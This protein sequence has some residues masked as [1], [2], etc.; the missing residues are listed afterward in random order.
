MSELSIIKIII[1]GLQYLNPYYV[2]DVF[3]IISIALFSI[4]IYKRT[5]II[6]TLLASL[7]IFSTILLISISIS[8]FDSN[9]IESSIPNLL[10]G[11]ITALIFGFINLLLVLI[12][13]FIKNRKIPEKSEITPTA[14]YLTLR[15]I[16]TYNNITQ[17]PLLNNIFEQLRLSQENTQRIL[18]LHGVGVSQELDLL[19]SIKNA[20]I[21]EDSLIKQIKIEIINGFNKLFIELGDQTETSNIAKIHT[22]LQNITSQINSI[23]ATKLATSLQAIQP[24]LESLQQLRIQTNDTFPKIEQNLTELIKGMQQVL[25]NNLD[26]LNTSVETQLDMAEVLIENNLQESSENS[27]QIITDKVELEEFD[28]VY[29]QAFSCMDSGDYE[30]AITY[31]SQA[32][33]INPQ[34]FSLFYNQAC[35]YA[36]FDQIESALATLQN[37][38]LLNEQ[39]IEMANTDLDFDKIRYDS[40]FQA[41]LN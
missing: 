41:L 27:Q 5:Q 11:L 23:P 28:A 12:L 1:I 32:I 22:E 25:Q 7:G 15:E 20:L 8:H 26:M 34:E 24:Y 10:N 36:M 40:R 33:E 6:P 19:K 30:N 4:A 16:A 39:C 29:N 35:C 3:L 18:E 2:A 9:S 21:D 14:I 17:K 31:F 37:A 38:I 13:R